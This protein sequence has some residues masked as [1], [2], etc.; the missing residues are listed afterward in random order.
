MVDHIVRFLTFSLVQVLA[1]AVDQTKVGR[2]SLLNFLVDDFLSFLEM[3]SPFTVANHNPLDLI[4]GEL[5]GANL[6]G[7]WASL[8]NAN[9][10]RSDHNV[11]LDSSFS[12]I[13]VEHSR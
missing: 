7:V 6:T 8:V 4:I 12:Q 9:I 1:H 13:D 10:L 2:S 3:S 5:F 11:V